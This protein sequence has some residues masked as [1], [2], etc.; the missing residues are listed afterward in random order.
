MKI[1]T[2]GCCVFI[3]S[4]RLVSTPSPVPS[5]SYCPAFNMPKD[6][7]FYDLLGVTR[8]VGEGEL[9]KQYR[10]VD[11]YYMIVEHYSCNS[12]YHTYLLANSLLCSTI[13][14]RTPVTLVL[15]RRYDPTRSLT[16]VQLFLHTTYSS[17]R[18]AMHMRFSVI[19]KRGKYITN[20]VKKA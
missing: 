1:K 12:L 13:L 8:D 14:I 17:K 3:S 19:L 18:L 20:T 4:V 7:K 11:I 2:Q 9:K 16:E 6:N 15:P 5:C 10:K